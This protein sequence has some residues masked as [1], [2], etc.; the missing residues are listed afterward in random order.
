M[1]WLKTLVKRLPTHLQERALDWFAQHQRLVALYYSL[2]PVFAW[3]QRAALYGRIMHRRDVEKRSGEGMRYAL[4]RSTHRIEKGLIM[5]PRREV[6]AEGYIEQAVEQ[7]ASLAQKGDKSGED[8][9]P[10][11]TWTADVLAAYFAAVNSSPTIERARSRYHEV[12]RQIQ[13]Q[14][15]DGKPYHRDLKPLN[16]RYEDLLELARRRRSVRWYEQRPVP[17]DVIDR[18]IEVARWS[19]SA[20]NR[21]PFEFRIFDDPE[22][23]RR[24]GALPMGAAHFFEKFP[25]LVV[26][27][28]KMRAFSQERDRHVMYIDVGLSGRQ[29][30]LDQLAGDPTS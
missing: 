19:P 25:C 17:R 8:G 21:Q 16:I 7:F 18:A 13:Y 5:R 1:R 23:V 10:L 22:L 15:G 11:L 4:R 27:I 20:C 2:T 3:E 9:D 29:L 28:G 12:L 30:V 24:V 14:P 26:V 6:F